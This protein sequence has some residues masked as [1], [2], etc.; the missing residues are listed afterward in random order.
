MS[1]F[2]VDEVLANMAEQA[3]KGALCYV[4]WTCRGC[5]DRCT[6]DEPNIYHVGGY[7]HD[8]CGTLTVPTG[9]NFLLIHASSHAQDTIKRIMKEARRCP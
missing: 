3:K 8:K 4:K 7:V 1:D 6:A 2:P 5:G 9:I